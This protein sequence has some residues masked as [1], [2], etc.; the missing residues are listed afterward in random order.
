MAER[1]V[2]ERKAKIVKQVEKIA[3]PTEKSMLMKGLS[4]RFFGEDA[5][6]LVKATNSTVIY[7]LMIWIFII[8]CGAMKR[9]WDILSGFCLEYYDILVALL[10]LVI[11]SMHIYQLMKHF[12]I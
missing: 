12:T 2:T 6:L 8:W 4:N 1:K 7:M 9:F 10:C 3:T 11:V 5:P